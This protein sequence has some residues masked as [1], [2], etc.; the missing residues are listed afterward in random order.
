MTVASASPRSVRSETRIIALLTLG[1]LIYRVVL[2]IAVDRI[3]W[4]DEPFYLWLGRNWLTGQGYTFTGYD[5]VH[6]T[7]L[8]PLLSGLVYL[9]TGNLQ[10]SSNVVYAVCGAL[11]TVPL[12]LI[13]YEMYG[14]RSGVLAAVL[15]GVWPAITI[16]VLHWGTM[17]EPPYLLFIYAG[18]YCG[19]RALR[20]HG[21]WSALLSGAF[22][23]LAYLTR[24]EAIGYLVAVIGMIVMIRAGERALLARR[25][26]AVIAALI[27]GYLI[28]FMPYAYYVRQHTGAWMVSEKAG[29]TYVTSKSLAYGDTATFDKLTWGLDS[30]GTEVFFFSPESYNVS[31][32]EVIQQDPW[33]FAELVYANVRRFANSLLSIRLFPYWLAPLVAFGWLRKAWTPQRLKA[34]LFLLGAISPVLGFLVFFIQDR[35]ILAI[36]PGL[37]IWAAHGLDEVAEWLG[38]TLAALTPYVKACLR[39][40]LAAALPLALV[41]AYLAASVP[42]VLRAANTGSWRWEHRSVG[43]ALHDEPGSV[44]MARYPAIAFYADKRWIPT[45]N[46]PVDDVLRYARAKGANLWVV[47]ERETLKLR[48]Q[49]APLFDRSR[50]TPGLELAHMDTS[51]AER[52][53]VYRVSQP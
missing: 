39:T 19:L 50:A 24:P 23:A 25:T 36:V 21:A 52:I 2:L 30:A 17:T 8:F 20:G 34:E 27:L 26:W 5:D 41:L 37:V 16:A 32:I 14:R 31:I 38:D 47:D 40:A 48:P 3:V 33:D 45:P 6:H 13:G 10:V 7:P 22:L 35:Y 28:F 42:T 49:F 44:L 11:F 51:S 18:I 4:G 29:V 15:A 53:A 12:Y 9:L 1:A 43:M 46:A